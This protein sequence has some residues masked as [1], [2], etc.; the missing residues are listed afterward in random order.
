MKRPGVITFIGVILMLQGVFG[1]VGGV[2]LIALQTNQSVIDAT[3][4]TK[5]ELFTSGLVQLIISAIV[6]LIALGILGGSRVS[7]GIVAAIQ[8]INV[9]AASW[10][11]FTHHQGAFLYSALITIA[12]AVFV[13]WALFN[14]K[15]D[16]YYNA[17]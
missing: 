5:S 2:V 16:E 6:I 15:S 10:A 13:L 7:R 11:M 4:A 17:T 9:A 12:I 14:E 1:A 3:G 8:I